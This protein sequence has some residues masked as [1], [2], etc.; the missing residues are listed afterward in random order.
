MSLEQQVAEWDFL[1]DLSAGGFSGRLPLLL[2]SGRLVFY[3]QRALR[4]WFSP[5]FRPNEHYVPVAEDLSNLV[6]QVEWA[7]THP[8]DVERIVSACRQ[9]ADRVLTRSFAIEYLREALVLQRE[10]KHLLELT[11]GPQHGVEQ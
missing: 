6:A 11:G 8:L 5:W 2:R 3:Q 9:Q 7:R 10:P 1:I 4:Q